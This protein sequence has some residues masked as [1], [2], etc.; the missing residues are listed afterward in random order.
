[1]GFLDFS[2]FENIENKIYMKK[3]GDP[4][5]DIRGVVSNHWPVKVNWVE[6]IKRHFYVS[7]EFILSVL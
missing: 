6:S 7:S 3:C 4:A 1:M 2:F 5:V